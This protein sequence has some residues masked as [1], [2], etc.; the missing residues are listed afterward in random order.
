MPQPTLLAGMILC[1]SLVYAGPDNTRRHDMA[2]E[3][4]ATALEN[5]PRHDSDI[6]NLPR[7][8]S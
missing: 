3:K 4:T 7:G 2:D 8:E 1:T 6:G 5:K